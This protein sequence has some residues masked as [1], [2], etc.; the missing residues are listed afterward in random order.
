MRVLVIEDDF[1]LR[2]VIATE[3]AAAGHQVQTAPDGAS[4]WQLLHSGAPLPQVIVL[5][6]MMPHMDGQTFRVQQLAEPKLAEI[7]TLVMTAKTLDTPTRAA[8]GK[9]PILAKPF[10]SDVLLAA[11]DEV[12]QPL[13][14]REKKCGCG[15]VYDEASWCTLPFV[16]RMDNGRE[17][18]ESLELRRCPCRS[19]LAWQLGPHAV[20]VP[21]LRVQR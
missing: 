18:G 12:V 20:S 8:L 15:R 2:E 1:D 5:D 9:I 6:L 4:A 13:H 14:Q 3:I 21:L 10:P 19:T 11:I 17:A 16:A 7:P